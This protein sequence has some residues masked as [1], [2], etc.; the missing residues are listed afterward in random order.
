M[1]IGSFAKY[2]DQ[3][4][5]VNKISNAAPAVLIGTSALLGTHDVFIKKHKDCEP[6]KKRAIR[7]LVILSVV[8]A[9]SLISARGL[10]VGGKRIFNGL[11]EAENKA[12]ILKEQVQAIKNYTGLAKSDVELK[13]ILNKAKTKALSLK[14]VHKLRK[15][16]KNEESAKELLDTLL[17]KNEELSSKE[18]FSE[19]G[20]LSLLGLVPVAAG[21]GAGMIA[22]RS[23]HKKA[24][25]SDRIKEG[26]Y[27]YFANIF[28]CNVGAGAAL[29][30]LE[31]LK[32]HDL[33]K[34]ITPAKKFFTMIGGIVA[35]G[36]I[37]GS[38]IANY[39]SKKIID[40]MVLK[41]KHQDLNFKKIYDERT[42]EGADMCMHVDDIATAGVLSGLKWIEPVLPVFYLFSGYRAGMGYR[43]HDHCHRH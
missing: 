13:S 28:L 18:I 37:G 5:I 10:S 34:K 4:L 12:D 40:P 8:S 41:K 23:P 35:T 30:G 14:E 43:N 27:Q 39:L 32:K 11:I 25:N 24:N 21:V 19:I 33:I 17:G 29:F 31:A 16:L 36:I 1:N 9:A 26:F 2:I 22:D 42:P 3:P 6:K 20:R 15:K 7:N 38:F